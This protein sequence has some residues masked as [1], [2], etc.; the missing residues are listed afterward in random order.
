MKRF[1]S[2]LVILAVLI[3]AAAFAETEVPVMSA[4]ATSWIVG[5]DPTAYIP[6][7]MIDGVETT[8]FQFSTLTTPLGKEYLY[9]YFY[10]PSDIDSLWIKNGFWKITNGL[11]QYTRN[12][13]VKTMTVEFRYS[14]SAA[15][16]DAMTV[17]LADDPYR[18]NWTKVS[19]GEHSSV[20]AVRFRITA[21][22]YGTRF[23]NDVCISEVKFMS[24]DGGGSG[25]QGGA[26][27]GL[28]IMKLAT[29]SGPGT[30][31]S[32]QGTYFVEGQYIR[33]LSR[34][35]DSRNEIWWVKC[36]IP[37]G[38]GVKILWT[39]YKRFDSSTLP[40]SSIPIE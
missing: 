23:P 17:T 15:Y 9:F 32:E 40:L 31:Y 14:Y 1:F 22:Y 18:V 10:G 13:R 29:R 39:G 4:D 34:A 2:L 30:Q 36:E 21:I 38:N 33:V 20:T 28:A 19:L 16:T 26:L 7:R 11:D 6:Q 35:W 37:Y 12:C 3:P 27:Y 5:K 8:S 25:P 24:G